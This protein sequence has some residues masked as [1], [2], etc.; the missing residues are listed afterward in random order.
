MQRPDWIDG[1]VEGSTTVY[2]L[3]QPIRMLLAGALYILF[4]LLITYIQQNP[5][6]SFAGYINILARY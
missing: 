2:F 6:P 4:V 5:F 3:I 1:P